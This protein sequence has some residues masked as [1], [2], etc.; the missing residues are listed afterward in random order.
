MIRLALLLLCL[1]GPAAAD[2]AT[3]PDRPPVPTGFA[4]RSL[5]TPDA[6][7]GL[8]QI[9][10]RGEG[11]QFELRARL[12]GYAAVA[13]PILPANCISDGPATLEQSRTEALLSMRFAC[14]SNRGAVLLPGSLEAARVLV[15][16]A[17]GTSDTTLRAGAEGVAVPLSLLWPEIL[18]WRDVG[19][20]YLK[21]GVE[22]VLIGLDHLAFVFCLIFL[23]RPRQLPWLITAFT[24]GHSVTLVLATLGHVRL[25][26]VPVEACI[27]L[28]IV[29]LAREVLLGR[30]AGRR[31]WAITLAFGLLHGLGFASA[32]GDFGLPEGQTALALAAFNVGVEIGQLLFV[33]AVLATRAAVER[34][35]P[36]SGSWAKPALL[37]LVGGFA[38]AWTVERTLLLVA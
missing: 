28:S 10:V 35:Y 5:S 7:L 33:A 38:L 2:F 17:S 13:A 37:M 21:S 27:A 29:F 26:I 4:P 6:D 11:G 32:L 14:E 34:F 20:T 22:H 1:A 16:S 36:A 31:E 18:S 30:G 3:M 8:A 9:T 24:L 25:P 19:W 23:A 12:S 15:Y